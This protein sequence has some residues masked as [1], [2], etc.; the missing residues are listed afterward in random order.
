MSVSRSVSDQMEARVS[1]R[2]LNKR[3]RR[4]REEL[5]SIQTQLANLN[6]PAADQYL[7]GGTGNNGLYVKPLNWL[8]CTIHDKHPAAPITAAN[9]CLLS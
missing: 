4:Q 5:S 6:T 2:K 9:A 7:K 3:L 1:L 8:A